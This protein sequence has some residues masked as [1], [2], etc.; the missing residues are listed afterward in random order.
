MFETFEIR[1]LNL[2]R[3]SNFVLRIFLSMIFCLVIASP[4]SADTVILKNKNRVE[5]IVTH[6]DEKKIV[7]QFE[8]EATVEFPRGEVEKVIYT[9]EAER[10]LLRSTW[11]KKIEM[12]STPP[13]GTGPQPVA[14]TQTTASSPGAPS[15]SDATSF[16]TTPP[17]QE[18][19]LI[20]A[21]PTTTPKGA[22]L[23]SE[24]TWKARKTQHFTVYFQEPNQGKAIAN[25]TEYCLEKIVDDLRLRKRHDPREKYTVYVVKGESQ[26]NQ[27]LEKLGLQTEL[28]GG[29]TTGSATREIF[30]H[31]DS[32]PY[33]QLAFPHEL[34]HIILEE[35]AQGRKIPLWFDEGFAN[36][37]G[38][39]IG[40]DEELLMEAL[41]DGKLISLT[42]LVQANAYPGT[43]E[44]KELFYTEAERFVEFL[45]TQYGRRKFGEFTEAL[46]KKGE[47]ESAFFSAYSGKVGTLQELEKSWLQYLSE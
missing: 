29:F 21:P 3:A 27:F 23:L 5:G 17:L 8:K 45:I 39:I 11:E 35:L 46:L 36:Y 30:L 28:T 4:L 9:S 18:V 31:A 25:R 19:A 12:P 40:I 1:I 13:A 15:A 24:G 33:L 2:F 38:G 20:P 44:K 14:G 6:E 32:I 37:E 47:F 10:G 34:T 22:L 16:Q 43:I 41:R 42:E 26:W 7:L